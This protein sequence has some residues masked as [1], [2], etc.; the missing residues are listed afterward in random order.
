MK[1]RM[2]F[3]KLAKMWLFVSVSCCLVLPSPI[4]GDEQPAYEAW[5][6]SEAKE[7]IGQ[8][9]HS[10][11]T[12][13]QYKESCLQGRIEFQSNRW[14]RISSNFDM[15]KEQL[16]QEITGRLDAGVNLGLIGLQG[17]LDY[18]AKIARSSTQSSLV[19]KL[20]LQSGSYTFEDRQ[21]NKR[22][23]AASKLSMEK[24]LDLCGDQYIY[25]IDVGAKMLLSATFEMNNEAR[26]EELRR[27]VSIS[28]LFGLFKKSKESL[29]LLR[30]EF[31][32]SGMLVIRAWQWGGSQEVLSSIIGEERERR[33]ELAEPEACIDLWEELIRYTK[34]QDQGFAQSIRP[35]NADDDRYLDAV[36]QLHTVPYLEYGLQ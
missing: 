6:D 1:N 21:L 7:R 8:G 10:E 23:E 25:Q 3:K 13:G 12:Q 28:L 5:S 18:L 4:I 31:Q 33:C 29:E 19:F 17:T 20:E 11:Q 9:F 22:G 27:K 36:L 15:D 24:R 34:D 2:S 30:N 14:S 16:T 32:E 26:L 35:Q